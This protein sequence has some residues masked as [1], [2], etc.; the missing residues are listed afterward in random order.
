MLMAKKE[1][2]QPKWPNP[3]YNWNLFIL[4]TSIV[5]Q[6]LSKIIQN[7]PSGGLSSLPMVP[8]TRNLTAPPTPNLNWWRNLWHHASL[9]FLA[10]VG[11]SICT[12][13]STFLANPIEWDMDSTSKMYVCI[14]W[15]LLIHHELYLFPRKHIFSA[16]ISRVSKGCL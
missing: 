2:S 7:W 5:Y 15:A 4:C 11:K 1:G 12:F 9:S 10:F 8:T 6:Y 14:S 16:M 13:F 3:K